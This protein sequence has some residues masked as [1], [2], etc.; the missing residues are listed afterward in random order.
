M[1]QIGSGTN[2]LASVLVDEFGEW[3]RNLATRGA[4]PCAFTGVTANGNQA[5][6][7]LTGLSLNHVQR[8]EFLIWLCRTESFV[9][10]AYSTQS[11]Q[12]PEAAKSSRARDGERLR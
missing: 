2:E 9:S 1:A 11:K 7:I 8:R 4:V 5:V 10:Y 12:T 3:Y 6:I